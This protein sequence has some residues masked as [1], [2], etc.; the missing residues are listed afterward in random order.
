MELQSAIYEHW[1]HVFKLDPEREIGDERL[2]AVCTS[3]TDAVIVGGYDGRH[4]R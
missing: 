4:V 1:R 3:G 2:D